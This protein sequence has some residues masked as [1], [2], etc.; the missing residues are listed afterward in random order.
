MFYDFK[1]DYFI[2]FQL[3]KFSMFSSSIWFYFWM[4]TFVTDWTQIRELC[5]QT[6]DINIEPWRVYNE[7]IKHTH[8]H[9][10]TIVM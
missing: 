5:L 3:L 4:C 9:T 7:M 1:D 10:H 6:E 8:T 2:N